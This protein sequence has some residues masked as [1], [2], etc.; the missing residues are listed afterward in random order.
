MTTP[1]DNPLTDQTPADARLPMQPGQRH[2]I[3]WREYVALPEWGIKHLRAKTDTGARTS[4]IDAYDIEEL[5]D[6][7]VRFMVVYSRL[8]PERRREV[9]APIA[10]RSTVTSSNGHKHDRLFIE[11]TI[12]IG[13]VEKKIEV[14]LV[15]RHKMKCR[16]L[17]GRAALSED[18]LVDP[19][20]ELLLTKKP[21]RRKRKPKP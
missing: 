18:F 14:S 8:H 6:G 20:R 5:G 11:T 7:N 9:I 17:I 15:H 3:G 16:M 12:K 13:P 1:T 10:R 19:Q 4:A 2:V 21:T